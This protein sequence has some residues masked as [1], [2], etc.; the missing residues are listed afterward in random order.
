MSRIKPVHSQSIRGQVLI[1]LV[2][3]G[4]MGLFV[5]QKDQVY[6][7]RNI[8]PHQGAR[9]SGGILS[10]GRAAAG[11]GKH[12]AEHTDRIVRCPWHNWAFDAADGTA[13]HAPDK[14]RVATYKAGIEDKHVYV[15]L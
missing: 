10:C 13:L 5:R 3:L 1:L 4:C 12:Q 15:V 6:A 14:V 11:V 7:L 8:C 9:L 2:T